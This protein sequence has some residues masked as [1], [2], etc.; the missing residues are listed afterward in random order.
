LWPCT[1]KEEQRFQRF[2]ELAYHFLNFSL[3]PPVRYTLHTFWERN[4]FKEDS[5][6]ENPNHLLFSFFGMKLSAEGRIAF[7]LAAAVSI[8]IIAI[9]WRF[10]V[11]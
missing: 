11:S 8:L 7:M 9:A 4:F 6:P 1:A 3:A 10:A 2:D 5:V